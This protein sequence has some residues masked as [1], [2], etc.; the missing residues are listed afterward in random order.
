MSDGSK[1]VASAADDWL[2][3]AIARVLFE[4]SLFGR[5]FA[6]FAFR[7]DRSARA[8]QAREQTFMNPLAFAASAAGVYWATVSLLTTLWPV[9]GTEAADTL[10]GQLTSA[11]GPYVH[12]GLLGIAMHFGLRT[13]GSKR[14]VLGSTGIAFFA[15]GSIGTATALVLTTLARWFGYE[16]GALALE[17]QSGDLVPAVLLASGLISYGVL[18]L[19]MARGMMGL[20]RAPVWK[21]MAAA[22]FAMAVTAF[23]FGSVLPEGSFGWR[24]FFQI[25]IDGGFT[26]HF[27]F[28]G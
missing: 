24:P 10:A 11:I 19:V 16:R 14:R 15:G 28:R 12:Y 2:R 21:A 1:S 20:H 22:G 17:V 8:W 9:P 3:E 23:L 4:L 5:T 13:L 6:A 26:L 18:C 7:P 27:G 25:G